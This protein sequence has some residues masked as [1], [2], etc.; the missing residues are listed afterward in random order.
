LISEKVPCLIASSTL[1]GIGVGVKVGVEVDA[2]L[3]VDVAVGVI[4]SIVD[5]DTREDV[6]HPFSRNAIISAGAITLIIG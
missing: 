6:P 2:G 4:V 5:G 3:S 1:T